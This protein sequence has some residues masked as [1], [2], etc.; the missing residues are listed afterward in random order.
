LNGKHVGRPDHCQR[1]EAA[2]RLAALVADGADVRV[3][4]RRIAQ[5]VAALHA[6]APRSVVID[7]AGLPETLR[8]QWDDN[9]GVLTGYAGGRLDGP[10]LQRVHDRAHRYLIGRIPLLDD[11]ILSGAIVEGHGGLLADDIICP[12]PDLPP[13]LDGSQA[14]DRRR[15]GDVLADIGL[16]AMDLE[17]LGAPAEAAALLDDYRHAAGTDHP[18]SLAHWYIAYQAVARAAIATSRPARPGPTAEHMAEIGRLLRLADR[19]LAAGRVR[20]ILVGGL[21]GTGKSTIAEALSGR[22][23]W[24]VIRSDAIRRQL[25]GPPAAPG[26]GGHRPEWTGATYSTLLDRAAVHLGRGRSILLDATWAD[27]MHRAAAARLARRTAADLVALNCQVTPQLALAR[28]A[29]R[30]AGGRD[31]RDVDA[32]AYRELAQHLA[33]WPGAT[34]LDTSRPLPETLAEA[35]RAVNR[36]STTAAPAGAGQAGTPRR[37]ER[38]LA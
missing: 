7:R 6:A 4:I 27:P 23:G 19:H 11:R 2:R 32:A 20:L 3:A 9:L 22:Y 12:P 36:D 29:H 5:Q 1:A 35:L 16:L 38:R 25:A 31:N 8:G 33:P 15:H 34:A 26:R 30:P 14:D 13:I 17:R 21:P 24:P 28:I 10:T 37:S 18:A